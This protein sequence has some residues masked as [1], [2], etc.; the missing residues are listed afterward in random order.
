MKPTGTT[1]TP[2]R[3]GTLDLRYEVKNWRLYYGLD[4]VGKMDSY[5]YLEED[6]ATSTYK[7]NTPEHVSEHSLFI[8]I[9]DIIRWPSATRATSGKRRWA[10]A[11]SPTS[12]HPRF[13]PRRGTTG[14]ATPR[15]TADMTTSAARSI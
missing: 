9:N 13:Q 10:Y 15:C 3:S 5:A 12:S 4:W 14:L 8:T 7:L 1:G 2:K 6:P 11:T